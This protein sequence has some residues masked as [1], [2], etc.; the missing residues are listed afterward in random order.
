V[1]DIIK[2]EFVI[3]SISTIIIICAYSSISANSSQLAPTIENLVPNFW[4]CK[5]G[6]V[7][8]SLAPL[9]RRWHRWHVVGTIGRSLARFFFFPDVVPCFLIIANLIV[10]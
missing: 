8:T 7:G 5:N 10:V 3:I 9:A 1:K 6:T 2:L 4:T